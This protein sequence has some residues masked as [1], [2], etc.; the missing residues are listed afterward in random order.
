MIHTLVLFSNRHQAKHAGFMGASSCHHSDA[1]VRAWWPEQR[2]D[3]LRG[4]RPDRVFVHS[5][6]QARE[7]SQQ[8]AEVRLILDRPGTAWIEL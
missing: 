7:G 4:V 8:F 6:F 1:G 5:A 3:T 2:T